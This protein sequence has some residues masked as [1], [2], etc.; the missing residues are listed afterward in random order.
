MF[1]S[2]HKEA[3]QA[4]SLKTSMSNARATAISKSEAAVVSAMTNVYFAAQNNL[5][6]SLVP[7]LNRLCILQVKINK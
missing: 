3:S 1:I 4:T 7:D 5:A 2:D 6:S